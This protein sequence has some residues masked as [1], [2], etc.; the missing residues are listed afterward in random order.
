MGGRHDVDAREEPKFARDAG[1]DEVILLYRAG[2][3]RRGAAPKRG[4][5][6][7]VVY[8]SVGKTTFD[9]SLDCLVPRGMMLLFGQSSGPVPPL[10]PQVLNR[11]GSLYLTRPTIAHYTATREELTARA[12]EWFSWIEDGW[13]RVHIDRTVPLG[14]ASAAHA[15]LE[16]RRTVGKVLL[17]SLTSRGGGGCPRSTRQRV[18]ARRIEQCDPGPPSRPE[19]ALADTRCPRTRPAPAR[20]QPATPTRRPEPS[21]GAHHLAGRG[22]GAARR[23]PPRIEQISTHPASAPGAGILR[24]QVM[25]FPA[26]L[27]AAVDREAWDGAHGRGS[28]RRRRRIAA[29]YQVVPGDANRSSA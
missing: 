5:G 4:K 26:G 12:S 25:V 22:P 24:E 27:E 3:R 28:R 1:A 18:E 15:A 14:E 21:P 23:T 17:V 8:D 11:K 10:D 6:V 13:L 20:H 9:G 2:L 29:R 7:H 16:S 19:S